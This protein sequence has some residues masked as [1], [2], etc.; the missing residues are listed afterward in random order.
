MSA[1]TKKKERIAAREAGNDKKALAAQREAE[2]KAKSRRRWTMGTIAVVLFIALILFLNSGFLYKNTTALSIG[3]ENYSPAEFNYQYANQFFNVANQYGSYASLMGLDTSTGVAGLD[4]Q[5]CPMLEDGTWKDYLMDITVD[6]MTQFKAIE[7][8]AVANGIALSE[9]EIA[10]VEAELAT[11]DS[12]A[13]S[14]GYSSADNFLDA[15]YGTGVNTKIALAAGLQGALVN[16]TAV[17]YTEALEYTAE[18]LDAQYESYNGDKDYFDYAYYYVAAETVE[19]E[20][21]SLNTTDETM[22]E[23]EA[24]A[25]A[26]LAAYAASEVEDVEERFNEAL[27][28]CGV[29]ASCIR[30]TNAGQAL[31]VYQDWLKAQNTVGEATIVANAAGDGFYVVSYI[32][33]NENDYNLAQVRHILVMAEAD[34]NGVF[35]DEAK[36]AAKAEAEAIYEQWKSGEATEESFAA[37]ANELS[38]DGGSNTNGGLYDDVQMGQMV[39]E[40]DQFCFEGHKSGDTAIVYGETV[41]Y[42]GY[43]IMYYVGEGENCRD[44]IARSELASADSEAWLDELVSG[45]EPVEKFWLKLAA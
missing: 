23:A 19:A 26:I 14:Q 12:Y 22:A 10:S 21:G 28:Q 36:A 1:S 8:Y 44:Y 18:E 7:D 41:S 33:R 39:E 17:A 27:A 34:E 45:Y 15:N 37:L 38:E 29:D 43:H 13:Q 5:A 30:T 32:D 24:K 42:A 2:L 9:E 35:T 3:D 31:G 20:D 16:K 25:E 6:A 40:F 4:E 11:F